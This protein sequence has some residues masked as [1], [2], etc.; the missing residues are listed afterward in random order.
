MRV[1]IITIK[2]R[3]FHLVKFAE[4]LKK[5]QIDCD[6]IDDNEFLD[7]SYNFVSKYKKNRKFKKKSI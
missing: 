3:I 2:S 5:L 4:E 6:I 1:L 7:K